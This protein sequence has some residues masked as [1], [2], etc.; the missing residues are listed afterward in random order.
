MREEKER[1]LAAG[2]MQEMIVRDRAIDVPKSRR[3]E[4]TGD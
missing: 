2:E 3:G 1:G 4:P